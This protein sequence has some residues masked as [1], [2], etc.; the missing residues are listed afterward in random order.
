M[1]QPNYRKWKEMKVSYEPAILDK[2]IKKPK[3]QEINE[4]WHLD[5]T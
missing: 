1:S 3:N 2:R 4:I 5:S